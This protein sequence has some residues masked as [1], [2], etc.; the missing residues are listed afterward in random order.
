MK[1]HFRGNFCYQT[2]TKNVYLFYQTKTKHKQCQAWSHNIMT[3]Q[4]KTQG[5]CHLV[6]TKSTPRSAMV[7]ITLAH[8]AILTITR[9]RHWLII[10]FRGQTSLELQ[11]TTDSPAGTKVF[12]KRKVWSG[13]H[14]KHGRLCLVLSCLDSEIIL[15][16][17]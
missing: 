3:K 1:V 5:V 6:W 2:F 10:K 14:L 4:L 7:L 12:L 15:I 16:A 11:L 9:L 13:G 8:A 17:V